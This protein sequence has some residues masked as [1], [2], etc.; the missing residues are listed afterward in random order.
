MRFF[1][2]L[3]FGIML[4]SGCNGG[5]GR[6]YQANPQDVLTSWPEYLEDPVNYVA[7]SIVVLQQQAHNDLAL[8]YRWQS[9][10]SLGY[11]FG[12][13]FTEKQLTL[14]GWSWQS[15]GSTYLGDLTPSHLLQCNTPPDG[16]ATGTII[17][18][19]DTAVFGFSGQGDKIKIIWQDDK[20]DTLILQNDSFLFFRSGQWDT[21]R[22]ELLDENDQVIE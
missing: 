14:S 7:G 13:T 17:H 19:N 21:P 8:L 1:I 18:G 5:W 2:V 10:T 3:L 11:C 12:L 15:N 9:P 20:I 22:F 6:P 4:L 16:L